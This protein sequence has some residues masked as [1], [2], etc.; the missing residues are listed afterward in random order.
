MARSIPPE[1]P[2]DP[3]L[4]HVLRA[5]AEEAASSG[6]NCML[7]GATARNILLT[8]VFGLP[9]GR[10]TYD[11]DFAMAVSG[12]AQFERLKTGISSRAGF[13]LGAAAQRLYYQDSSGGQPYPLDLVPF[14]GIASDQ[15][16]IVWPPDMAV[17][18]SVVGYDEVFAA[19][20]DVE[21]G[22][23]LMGRVASLPGLTVLKLIAWSE[24]GRANPKDA[25]DLFQLMNSYADAGN[26][27]RL[28]D[29]EYQLLEAAGHDPDLAGACLLGKDIARLCTAETCAV[30]KGVIDSQEESLAR[31]MA[32]AIRHV[33]GA[34]ER[35]KRSLQQF[36]AG[37]SMPL[38]P[39]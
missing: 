28:Y 38:R 7:V 35:V 21:L 20:E 31:A 36:R 9:E 34:Q 29:T 15:G 16:E 18:M 10:A 39:K 4:L 2:L 22:P 26:A 30:L 8:H 37:L 32:G 3:M 24:R 13:S 19:A 11:V 27:A 17:V 5:V 14:G 1:R 12:W 25:H 6:I 23:G 33:E